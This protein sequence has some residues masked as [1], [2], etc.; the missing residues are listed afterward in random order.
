[1]R[2]LI[3]RPRKTLEFETPAET[4]VLH[5]PVEPTPRKRTFC[6]ARPQ[7]QPIALERRIVSLLYL[8]RSDAPAECDWLTEVARRLVYSFGLRGL[9]R[10]V[11]FVFDNH[12]LD[13]NRRRLRCSSD[14]I[15]VQ[16][17]VFDLLVYLVQNRDRVV[18]KDDLIASVWGGRL[19]SESA[20][21]S[22]INAARKAVGD[23]GKDQKIIRTIARKGL[24]FVGAVQVQPAGD[25][26]C[27]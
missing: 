17:Q 2:Q 25:G 22:R 4:P 15:A 9:S 20:Q 11:Q 13:T 24:R 12:T 26:S 27:C 16:P 3:W 10:D 7:A 23:S 1:V 8:F 19:V 14:S 18:S 5:R 21:T 6:R